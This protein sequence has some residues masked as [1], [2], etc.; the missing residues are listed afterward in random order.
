VKCC[1]RRARRL[2]ERRDIMHMRTWNL[3]VM[4]LSALVFAPAAALAG[5]GGKDGAA[6]IDREM[7]MMDTNGDNKL[8]A[9]E[10]ATGAREMFAKM[11]GDKDGKVTATEMETARAQMMGDKADEKSKKHGMSAAEKI[12]VIDTNK[13]GSLSAEEQANG[14]RQMFAAMDTDKDG[15]LT[16]AEL[17]SGHA[18][19]LR[20]DGKHHSDTK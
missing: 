13:D 2:K 19:M 8:S 17:K 5:G 16:R 7:K 4:G 10:H 18:K 20:H 9:E 6:F 1:T 14:A 15:S 12:A 11:D 3:V